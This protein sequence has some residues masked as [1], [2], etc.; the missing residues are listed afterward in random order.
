[1]ARRSPY[2]LDSRCFILR[3]AERA[4]GLGFFTYDYASR[5]IY[6]N[7][8]GDELRRASSWRSLQDPYGLFHPSK[9]AL[10]S[11]THTF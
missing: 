11:A 4:I 8:V 5:L 7:Y 1:M 6:C 2:R 10:F 9:H 3:V